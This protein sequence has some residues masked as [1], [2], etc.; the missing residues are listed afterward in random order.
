MPAV[1]PSY[2]CIISR[3]RIIFQKNCRIA[4]GFKISTPEFTTNAN[5]ISLICN[6]SSFWKLFYASRVF[7]RACSTPFGC[8]KEHVLRLPCVQKSLFYA[9]RLFRRADLRLP[10]VPK[11]LFYV[12]RLFRR[13]CSIFSSS[14][15][16]NP[17]G[18]SVR[19]TFSPRYISFLTISV[20]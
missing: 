2:K 4:R 15:S 3:I 7:R 6:P 14:S 20:L 16:F 17:A 8:L 19:T 10:V 1:F 11:S 13:A 9:F 12:S 5:T 18:P